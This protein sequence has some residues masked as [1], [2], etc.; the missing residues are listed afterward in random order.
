[1][2]TNETVI[3]GFYRDLLTPLSII[4]GIQAALLISLRE[5]ELAFKAEAA[6]LIWTLVL[7][8]YT[9]L[10]HAVEIKIVESGI[11]EMRGLK[12]VYFVATAVM[13]IF[14]AIAVVYWSNPD[15]SFFKWGS[16]LPELLGW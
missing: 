13:M 8:L 10:A 1:M 15:W 4:A 11:F 9:F 6:L 2:G 5:N 14:T 12:Y 7:L 3:K 16:F